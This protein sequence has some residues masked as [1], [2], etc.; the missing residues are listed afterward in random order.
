VR[1]NFEI[2]DIDAGAYRL[3]IADGFQRPAEFELD[4]LQ[5]LATERTVHVTLECAGN[6]RALMQPT[7]PGTPWHLGAVSSAVFTGV[8]LRDVLLKCAPDPAAT[9]I[10]FTGHDCGDVDDGRTETFARSLPVAE[11]M[12]P[13]VLLAWAMNGEPLPPEHG[14]PLR[15]VVP[16][17]Y[18]IASVKWLDSIS[19]A[20][21]PFHG[22][23][24]KERYVYLGDDTEPDGAPVT[25]MRVRSLILSPGEHK[26]VPA[27]RPA[28]IRG[29]AWSGHA[30]IA[31]VHVNVVRAGPGTGPG[32]G[33][34][35][36]PGDHGDEPGIGWQPAVLA[37][38]AAPG[39]PRYWHLDWTP[40]AGHYVLQAKATDAAGNTQPDRPPR[41]DLGYA[42]NAVQ[43]VPIM[44]G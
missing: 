5:A 18:G 9:E 33:A 38:A 42:N 4:E 39:A 1:C 27:G 8:P 13:D 11:A 10:V 7:P 24:Q 36:G 40:A 35:A 16:G 43:S 6:G 20:D 34:G 15:L 31:T 19:A 22:Y 44:A 41:N 29:I 25:R 26:P 23:F 12:T 21:R 14:A 17:W 37:P 3:R 2:P 28:R 30:D 32:A